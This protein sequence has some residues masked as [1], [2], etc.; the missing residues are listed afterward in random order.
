[1]DNETP[2]PVEL[3][4]AQVGLRE[5]TLLALA[6]G[7]A[8]LMFDLQEAAVIGGW[9]AVG[10]VIFALLRGPRPSGL[11]LFVYGLGLFLML[12]W[13]PREHWWQG[14][15]PL[16]WIGI[17]MMVAGAVLALWARRSRD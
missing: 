9:I 4:P 1:M 2:V 6:A 16:L 10:L 8:A 17:G 13:W 11:L 14:A 3:K 12:F 5:A 7:Y 15:I